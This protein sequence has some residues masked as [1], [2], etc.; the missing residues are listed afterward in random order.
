MT[1]FAIGK[2]YSTRSACDYDTIY[3]WTVVRRT[4]KQVILCDT[5]GDEVRCGVYVYD[6]AEHCKPNGTY[7]MCPVISADRPDEDEVETPD[8]DR[9][10]PVVMP[11]AGDVLGEEALSLLLLEREIATL[12]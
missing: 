11:L 7:S 4:A 8:V 5:F 10:C 12:N 9:A 1:K 6:G 3:S 2:T